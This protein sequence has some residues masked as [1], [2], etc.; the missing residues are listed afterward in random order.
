MEEGETLPWESSSP[1]NLK[2]PWGVAMG[3]LYPTLGLPLPNHPGFP[4]VVGLGSSCYSSHVAG[5]ISASAINLSRGQ[6]LGE[7]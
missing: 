2:G 4:A 5:R 1:R 7:L 3:G 6:S